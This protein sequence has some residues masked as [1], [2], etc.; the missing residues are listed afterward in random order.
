MTI[1]RHSTLITATLVVGMV[2]LAFP[3]LGTASG[4]ANSHAKTTALAS[5]TVAAPSGF[6]SAAVNPTSGRRTGSISFAVAGSAGC[7]PTALSASEWVGSVQRYFEH[8]SARPQATLILCV[9]QFR[10]AAYATAI[11]T[12]LL[13]VIGS[14]A[15]RLKDIPGTWLHASGT[16]EE[17]FF[18]KG[19][20][21]VRVVSTD[22]VGSAMAL[23]LGQNLTQR[24]YNRLP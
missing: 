17:I 21:L 1:R 11:R 18:A 6:K 15:V 23:T 13:T 22:P 8:D 16:S 3:L 2:L 4:A 24:E 10:T 9:T 14:S 7:D 12:R 5:L 19:V 20:Y